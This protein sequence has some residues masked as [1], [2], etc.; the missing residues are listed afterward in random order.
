[1]IKKNKSKLKRGCSGGE[2]DQ[3]EKKRGQKECFFIIDQTSLIKHVSCLKL[4]VGVARV[5]GL[6]LHLHR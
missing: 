6:N 5:V 2:N 3:W 4:G 1:M